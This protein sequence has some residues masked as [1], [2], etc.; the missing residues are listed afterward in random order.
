MKKK[1]NRM[2]IRSLSVLLSVL[3]MLA[4]FPLSVLAVTSDETTE[5][6]TDAATIVTEPAVPYELV[7]LRTEN[8]KYYQILFILAIICCNLSQ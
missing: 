5:V 8:A 4:M 3:M 2:G 6:S 1:L 7:E